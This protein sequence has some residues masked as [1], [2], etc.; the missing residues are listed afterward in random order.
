MA[1]SILIILLDRTADE[2]AEAL[3][4][5]YSRL[6]KYL[7]RA[8][9]VHD[10]RS[11]KQT[12]EALSYESLWRAVIVM[13]PIVVG[14]RYQLISDRLIHYARSGGT[15]IFEGRFGRL[16]R[17]Q[18]LNAYF[19]DVWCIGWRYGAVSEAW[20]YTLNPASDLRRTIPDQHPDMPRYFQFSGLQLA[21]VAIQE[22]VYLPKWPL[23]TEIERR[24]PKM[25]GVECMIMEHDSERWQKLS[26]IAFAKYE[27]GWIGWSGD[28][29][30][31]GYKPWTIEVLGAMC[32]L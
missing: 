9:R 16:L 17:P 20:E 19:R 10:V 18:D 26:P 13:E 11:Y 21:N 27:R 24:G 30:P 2:D 31:C 22:S 28:I 7:S 5:L 8:C 15:V 6:I 3:I 12:L 14:T 29:A 1:D 4:E 32:G 25:V 23:T